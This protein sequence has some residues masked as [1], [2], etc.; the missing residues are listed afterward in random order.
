M[1]SIHAHIGEGYDRVRIGVGHPGRK[2]L[3]P[4]YVLN[5]FAKADADW[6]EDLLQGIADGAEALARGDQGRFMNAVAL[7]LN[8]PRSSTTKPKATQKKV[9]EPEA[10]VDERNPLQ[11]LMDK[12][13]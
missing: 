5:D 7:R 4:N 9:E 3:V 1:R 13:R 2:E 6:I 8:P 11:K 12:F 10:E